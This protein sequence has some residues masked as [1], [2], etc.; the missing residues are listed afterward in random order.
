MPTKDLAV[1]DSERR[2][3]WPIPGVI[4]RYRPGDTAPVGGGRST[5][6][7]GRT[8]YVR[9]CNTQAILNG[10]WWLSLPMGTVVDL[11]VP[12]DQFAL[13]ETFDAIPDATFETV[14]VA[15]HDPDCV[16]PYLWAGS[17]DPDRL[18]RTLR[19]DSTTADVRRLSL[20]DG[21]GLYR[22]DWQ[23]PVRSVIGVFVRENG[24]LL[25]ARAA[26][27]RWELRVLFPDRASVSTTYSSWR[28][29]GIDPSIQRVNGVSHMLEYGGVELSPC[30]HETLMKAFETNYYDVPRGITLDGLSDELDVSH[31]ALSERLR[32]GHRNII[33]TVLRDQPAP[34]QQS[35]APE[36]V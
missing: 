36:K 24:S 14:R 17:A 15:A 5:C 19:R 16:M 34:I 11:M 2:P 20:M 26:E 31:Q 12:T 32:R 21:R 10:P 1:R 4:S 8:L 22:I 35:I 29:H 9:P 18:E 33:E 27:D 28:Q 23:S 3:F 6:H 30:Q 13:G 25:K 7:L